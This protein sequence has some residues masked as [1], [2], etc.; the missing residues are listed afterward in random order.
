M[1]NK[2]RVRFAPSPTGF[3]HLGNIRVALMNY[4]FA[5]QK[6]GSFVLRIEDTDK[7]R[8]LS[9]AG[10]Q[11]LQDLKWLGLKYTEGPIIGGEFEPYYQ[12]ERTEI[13]KKQLD[14]LIEP[15]K[16][17]RCFCTKERLDN[18]REKQVAAGQPPRYDRTCLDLSDDMIKQKIAVGLP[19]LWR[20]KINQEQVF[21]VNC[22]ARGK[23]RFEMKNFSDFALTRHDGS[24]TFMFAN[25]VDDWLMQITN[26]IRGEDHLSNTAMQAALFDAF[27]VHM[28]TF[29]HLPMLCSA[30]GK[31][32]SKRD[33]GFSLEDLKH[34]GFLP[35]AI[36]NYLAII[37]GS[38][39]QEIQSLGELAKSF[40]FDNIH[41]TGAI[42][43]DI[44]KL[45]WLNHKWIERVSSEK[46][47]ELA[48]EFLYEQIPASQS[49]TQDKLEFLLQKVKTD[50][51]TLKDVGP[52]LS[53]YFDA[54]EIDI[55]AIQDKIG[56]D[57]TKIIFELIKKNLDNLSQTEFFLDSLKTEGKE[58]GL[59]IRDVFGTIRYLLTGKFQGV[60]IHDLFEIL[61]V[62]KIKARLSQSVR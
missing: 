50:L 21:D 26:V 2:V 39:E 49:V 56:A 18:M 46:L 38:F 34:E 62:E 30:E 53:F 40:D 41:S 19:F 59:K 17:Y 5:H 52:A 4:L 11:I 3:M 47:F 42:R 37:G 60:G 48:A 32:L 58:K 61:E 43:Y 25:F 12:S 24:F 55:K 54:P 15:K 16:V 7:F 6:K 57:K 29:W 23:T 22:M 45:T 13:Y 28:P 10:F 27:A 35:Q 14:Q 36:C 8:N 20:F 9:E 51:K 44:E 31:K 1:S 33:F